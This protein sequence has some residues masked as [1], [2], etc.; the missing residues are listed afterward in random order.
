MK[1]LS[2][3]VKLEIEFIFSSS[4]LN[5]NFDTGQVLSI[6]STCSECGISVYILMLILYLFVVVLMKSL[7]LSKLSASEF[8]IHVHCCVVK[9]KNKD[10]VLSRRSNCIGL[11]Q[12][13]I[14][15]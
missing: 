2:F 9:N 12:E 13:F 11:L 3:C 6:L 8:Q 1:S 15:H 14:Q 10:Y 4:L 7:N 5:M